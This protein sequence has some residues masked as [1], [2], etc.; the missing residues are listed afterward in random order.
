ALGWFGFNPGSTLGASGAGNLRFAIVAT[1]T[2][3]ASAS[4]A[5]AA[6]FYTWWKQG[7][8]D[9]TMAI[10]GMLAGLVAITAPSGFVNARDGFLIGA[11]AG[12]LVVEA[13][14][15]IDR[16]HVDDP[17]GAIAVHGVNGLWGMIALGL[18]A[19]GT[20]GDGLNGVTGC[21]KGL[22]YGDASQLVAQLIG[23]VTVIVWAFGVSYLFFKVQDKLMGIRVS[24]AT[25]MEG[26]D[27]PEV[28]ISG[29]PD[30]T[31]GMT[32]RGVGMED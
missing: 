32:G 10:N 13:V 23:C 21:V 20:Y 1:V 25:E 22:F 11:I 12:I 2:M 18:F 16:K 4:G 31:F 3:L 15:F 6:T 30:I 8:P 24:Q 27:I 5:L 29:Y 28:G 26:L 14:Y 19:D 17:V 9:P 7:K